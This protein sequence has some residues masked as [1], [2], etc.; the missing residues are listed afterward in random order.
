MTDRALLEDAAKASGLDVRWEL[1]PAMPFQPR[2][3][4]M[5]KCGWTGQPGEREWNP[6]TDDGDA[7]RLM[8]ATGLC[9]H[10]EEYHVFVDG[11]LIE[12]DCR[13]DPYVATRRAIVRAA[14]AVW[15]QMQKEQP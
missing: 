3:Q 9:V 11:T 15:E 4:A 5:I 10:V 1:D 14:A 2:W 6:L 8:V 7:L 12:E 13:T